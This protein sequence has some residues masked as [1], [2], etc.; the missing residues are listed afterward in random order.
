MRRT[1][2]NL[3]Y[4]GL[5]SSTYDLCNGQLGFILHPWQ[6]LFLK[7]FA[8]FF[9]LLCNLARDH[10]VVQLLLVLRSLQGQL[11]PLSLV[12]YDRGNGGDIRVGTVHDDREV[13]ELVIHFLFQILIVELILIVLLSLGNFKLQLIRLHR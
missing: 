9:V 6:F 10:N 1:G 3:L 2:G 5:E 11:L 7:L 12:A 13:V 4:F 8:G